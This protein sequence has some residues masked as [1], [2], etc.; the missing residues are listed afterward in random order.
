[1]RLI[2]QPKKAE[3]PIYGRPTTSPFVPHTKPTKPL[4]RKEPM[5]PERRKAGPQRPLMMA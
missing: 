2:G 1:M 4:A 3:S 5:T